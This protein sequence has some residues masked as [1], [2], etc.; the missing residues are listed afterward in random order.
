M[1]KLR[2]P[3]ESLQVETFDAGEAEDERG[4]VD[5]HMKCTRIDTTCNPDVTTVMT[6][7]CHNCYA[8]EPAE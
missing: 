7:A 3:V 4:T 2:L 5:A 6:G 8:P 1:E